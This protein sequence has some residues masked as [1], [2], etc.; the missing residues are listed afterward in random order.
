MRIDQLLYWL[1][2]CMNN[3]RHGIKQLGWICENQDSDSLCG[4]AVLSGAGLRAGLRMCGITNRSFGAAICAYRLPQIPIRDGCQANSGRG[5]ELA[6]WAGG[7]CD[8]HVKRCQRAIKSFCQRDVPRIVSCEVVT[9][10]PDSLGERRESK[11]FNIQS[12]EIT[13]SAIRFE[14][15]NDLCPFE[16]TKHVC[17]FGQ[18]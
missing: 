10:T 17:S 15:R 3:H 13:V 2:W 8:L 12:H 1:Y 18:D 7:A 5:N 11:Q 6:T 16:T 14:S 9:Q 4:S